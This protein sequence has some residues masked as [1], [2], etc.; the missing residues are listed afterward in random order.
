MSLDLNINQLTLSWLNSANGISNG[1][2]GQL[3]Q[4]FKTPEAIWDNLKGEINNFA[5]IKPETANYLIKVHDKY[6]AYLIKKL[7]EEKASIVTFYDDKYPEK[8]RNIDGFPYILYYKGNLESVNNISIAVVGSRKATG[9]GKY[10]AEKLTGE[11]SALG[12]TI[13]SGLAS[14][15]DTVAHRTA[16]NCNCKT[17]GV[18]GCGIN[19]IYPKKNQSL[20]ED[21]LSTGGAIITEFPFG[22]QP[23]PSNFPIRNRIISGLSNGVLI[24]EAQEKS[25][26]L[27]TAGHAANQGKDIFA[28]PGN[29]DSIYSRGTNAL[30]KDGAK[31]VTS[32]DDII[33]EIFEL[34]CMVNT[35]NKKTVSSFTDKE[36]KLISLLK[37]GEKTIYE[38][39]ENIDMDISEIL[40][41]LTVLEMKGAVKQ[42]PG[43]KFY[44][45]LR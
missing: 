43:N 20:Y 19:V 37:N 10:A 44:S 25:G 1:I 24:V 42:M 9:Y 6:E 7:N 21:I 39:A 14:G 41:T 23:M 8:L 30:I 16:I 15:I 18:I 2:M 32:V 31:I 45:L 11:L 22:M 26:T 3:I 17:V 35:N 28:V 36:L 38:A 12:V 4:Y 33:E 5:G 29:I 27:I 34:R 13:I 40:S